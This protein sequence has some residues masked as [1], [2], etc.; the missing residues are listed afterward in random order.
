[1]S[2]LN[3]NEGKEVNKM[4]KVSNGLVFGAVFAIAL[5]L[6]LMGSTVHAGTSIDFSDGGL[7]GGTV[8]LFSSG[9]VQGTNIPVD[10]MK[11]TIGSVTTNY[12]TQGAYVTG[13]TTDPTAAVLSFDKNT[14]TLTIV[15]GISALGISTGTTLLTMTGNFNTFSLTTPGAG[16]QLNASGLDVKSAV[17]LSDLGLSGT[18]WSYFG[19][20]DGGSWTTGGSGAVVGSG[21]PVSTDFTNTAVPEPATLILLGLGLLGVGIARKK[22]A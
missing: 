22:I 17:L 9:D 7:T 11:V 19:F 16:F 14:N 21:T 18:N 10:L 3:E 20:T 4:R 15:G 6:P 5:L 8:Q 1:M 2:I 13:S 12:D